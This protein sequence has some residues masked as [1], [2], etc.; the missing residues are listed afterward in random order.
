MFRLDLLASCR[1]FLS[2][3]LNLGAVF[4]SLRVQLGTRNRQLPPVLGYR[5]SVPLRG[6]NPLRPLLLCRELSGL[7]LPDGAPCGRVQERL[8]H[9][10][11]RTT[12][13]VYG[14]LWEGLDGAAADGL[15]AVFASA[16]GP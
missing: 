9:A 1:Y 6:E 7:P 2:V 8:G 5:F 15:D 13:D 16:A 11:I 4:S 3:P 12:L 10:S 14:H